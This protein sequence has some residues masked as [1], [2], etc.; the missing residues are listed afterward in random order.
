MCKPEHSDNRGER[1]EQGALNKLG[2]LSPA[3][4]SENSPCE[5]ARVCEHWLERGGFR[6]WSE[7]YSVSID[8]CPNVYP[9][10]EIAKLG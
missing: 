2:V 7:S 4:L 6:A 1:E 5:F 3:A 10:S 8:S 9:E